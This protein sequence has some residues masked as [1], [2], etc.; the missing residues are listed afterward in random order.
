M[1]AGRPHAVQGGERHH[2]EGDLLR[3]RRRRRCGRGLARL[4]WRRG[5]PVRH[6]PRHVRGRGRLAAP[7]APVRPLRHQD[8]LVH[9]RALDRDLSRADAGGRRCRPRDRHARLFPREPDRHDARAGGGGLRQMHRVHH[10][11]LRTV[12]PR[13]R[14]SLVGV[15]PQDQRAAARQG[16]QVR[17]L[18]D[19]QRL[20]SLLHAGRRQLDQDRFFG[21]STICRR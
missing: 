10:G 20:P 1:V 2:G 11:A 21:R 9:P 6:Q 13:L 15:R 19:A 4:L 5:Q 18:P 17:P 12:A 14:R 3:V 8:H 7:A 16:H